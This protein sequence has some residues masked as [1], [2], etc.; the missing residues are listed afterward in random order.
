[1]LRRAWLV[2]LVFVPLTIGAAWIASRTLGVNTDTSSMVSEELPWRVARAEFEA[3]F[4]EEGS[5]I[6]VLIEGGTRAMREAGAREMLERIRERPDV[7]EHAESPVADEFFRRHALFYRDVDQLR[8]MEAGL[9]DA[10][11]T[12]AALR[13]N[14]TISGLVPVLMGVVLAPEPRRPA[15]LER[16]LDQAAGAFEAAGRGAVRRVDWQGALAGEAGGGPVYVL[17]RPVLDFDAMFPA[18]GALD[19]IE[20]IT[21]EIDLGDERALTFRVTG[22]AALATDELRSAAQGAGVATGLALLAVLVMLYIGLQS[23]RM[24]LACTITLVVG[25]IG[26]GAFAGVAVGRLNLIS[27]AFAVLYIGLGIDYA[28]HIALRYRE[29]VVRG[30]S[31]GA[32]ALVSLRQT[33]PALVVCAVT[34]SIGFF[35]FIPTAFEGVSELGLIAGVGMFIGLAVNLTLLPALLVLFGR[36]VRY[37][38][39][40]EGGRRAVRLAGIP[41]RRRW[42]FR[43]L[44]LAGAV[45]ALVMAPRVVF[46]K[47]RMNLQNPARESVA[48]FNELMAT[49]DPSPYTLRMLARDEGEAEAMREALGALPS[50]RHARTIASFVPEDQEEK[51]E[52]IGRLRRALEPALVVQN[53]GAE[54]EPDRELAALVALRDGLSGL[55]LGASAQDGAIGRLRGAVDAFVRTVDGAGAERERL[56]EILRE[57][58]L[59]TLDEALAALDLALTPDRV[60]LESLPESIRARWIAPD[61]RWRVEVSPDEDLTRNEAIWRF[62]EEVL[63]VAPGAVGEP[64]SG[65][66]GGRVIAG[67]FVQA[68]GTALVAIFVL[69]LVLLRSVRDALVVLSPLLLAGGLTG[70]ASVWLGVPLNFANIIALPLMLGVGV[71]SGIHMVHRARYL[72]PGEALLSSSTARGVLFSSLT[73]IC[74]FG[75]LAI[76]DHLGMASMGTLLT[77]AITLTL[78]CTLGLLPALVRDRAGRWTR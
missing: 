40:P 44:G 19:A 31:H 76:S 45:V 26:T 38:A 22:E 8:A 78:V 53:E 69:V 16:L 43:G 65:L 64:V 11:A 33:G 41:E 5:S 24:M 50:V 39:R 21:R 14:P 70:A 42:L 55:E 32:A 75:S 27:V 28:I 18:E 66:R 59:G 1:M 12:L 49:G 17:A 48:A 67:A 7:F 58:L 9:R 6:L 13:R 34:T 62:A 23:V 77:I 68:I 71:D 30:W 35:A 56:L 72:R 37:R 36:P 47:N 73:T 46:D 20:Q 74:S 4:P 63:R 2:V 25:L 15:G 52:I 60:T 3:A 61:G 51:L 57:S 29:A 54:P 10:A